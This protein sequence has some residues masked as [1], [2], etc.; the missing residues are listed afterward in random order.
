M[1]RQLPVTRYNSRGAIACVPCLPAVADAKL[2][3]FCYGTPSILVGRRQSHFPQ[4]LFEARVHAYGSQP[5]VYLDP[6]KSRVPLFVGF[7]KPA[8][9][10]FV[11]PETNVD[12]GRI[13]SGHMSCV[14]SG[15]QLL[16]YLLAL[17]HGTRLRQSMAQSGLRQ[18]T[19]RR[20][21]Y[22]QPVFENGPLIF[23][24]L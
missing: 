24:A 7:L 8:Q 14:R 23:A 10:G 5:W 2:A 17:Q 19:A 21:L 20:I 13:E 22:R 9:G 6:A 16:E 11:V 1:S 3:A 12:G 15:C 4:Q 18:P